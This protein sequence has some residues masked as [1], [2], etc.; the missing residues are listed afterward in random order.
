MG[1]RLFSFFL[2][3]LSVSIPFTGALPGA[4]ESPAGQPAPAPAVRFDAGG[5]ALNIPFDDD[6]GLVFVKVRVND[7]RP[8]WFLLDS[9]FDGNI[10]STGLAKALGVALTDVQRVPQ[11]GGEIEMGRAA[12]L[13][14][15][16]PGVT[17]AG[18]TAQTAPLAPLEPFIGRSLDG[19][20]GHSFI[21]QLVVEIDYAAAVLNLYDPAA[22]RY[23]GGGDILP[24]TIA[25]A[26]PFV[27]GKVILAG[28]KPIPG[29]FKLDTGSLDTIGFNRNYLAAHKLPEA[30][31][32]RREEP[33]LAVGGETRGVRFRVDGFQLG[34]RVLK[35]LPVAGTL[36]SKGFEDRSD[37]GTIGAGIL[38]RFRLILD[39]ARR[40]AILEPN[41]RFAGPFP[42]DMSGAWVTAGGPDWQDFRVHRV[43]PATPAAEAGLHE[44]DVVLAVD[45][46]LAETLTLARVRELLQG[47]EGQARQLRIRRGDVELTVE[48]KLRKLI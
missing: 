38:G 30:G 16:L 42:Y 37:A 43:L 7:S 15:A 14:L 28:R 22:W 32:P 26:Q 1:H 29:R 35:D 48:L 9:G 13:T 8:A 31:R 21:R 12:G 41:S 3:C 17:L 27:S 18:Q 24:V 2:C 6:F 44:G 36:D 39:Y 45:G 20:L 5:Q 23:A 47:P 11:P 33:G 46:R 4:G 10:L 25:Q 40:R 34:R 19:I